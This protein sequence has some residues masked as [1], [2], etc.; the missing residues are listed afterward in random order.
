MTRIIITENLRNTNIT[1]NIPITIVMTIAA[2]VMTITAVTV[3]IPSITS[4]D[5]LVISSMTTITK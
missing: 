2:I 4:T 3:I 5:S 1:M